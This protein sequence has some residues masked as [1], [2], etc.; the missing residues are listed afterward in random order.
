[1]NLLINLLL[2]FAALQ[3]NKDNPQKTGVRKFIS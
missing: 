1:M 2:A 3:K